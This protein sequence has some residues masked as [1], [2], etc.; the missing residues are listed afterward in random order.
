MRIL[1]TTGSVATGAFHGAM[2]LARRSAAVSAA[3]FALCMPQASQAQS[4][5]GAN[6]SLPNGFVSVT[7]EDM[8]LQTPAGPVKWLRTWDGVEWKFNPHWESLSHSWGNLTGSTTA[9]SGANVS[10]GSAG[11]GSA[12]DPKLASG[13]PGSAGCWVWVDEDWQPSTGTV[14]VGQIPHREPM[15]TARTAP[16]NRTIGDNVLASQD[17]YAP[18]VRVNV[19]YAALCMGTGIAGGAQDMEAVRR[20]NELYVGDGG[21]MAFNNRSTLEKRAVKALPATPSTAGTTPLQGGQVQLAPVVIEK[22][23]RWVDRSGDWIDY[24]TPGQVV[25]YGDRNGNAVWLQRDTEGILRGV[26]DAT[27]HVLLTLHYQGGLISEVRDY[28]RADNALDLPARSVKYQYDEFNRLVKV[29]GVQGHDTQYA[30]DPNHKLT[31]ITDAEGRQENFAYAGTSISRHTAPDGAVTDY[32]FEFDDTHKQF[33]SKVKGPET[34]TGRLVE[35]VTHNRAGQLVRRIVNGRID[36]ELRYD[37]GARAEVSTNARGFSTR[38]T[39]N[40]FEQVV[41][42]VHADRSSIKR[43]YSAVH[44]ELTEE[45]DEE[46]V[47][48]LYEHDSKG[49]LLKKT[50]AAG[51]PAQRV[52]EYGLNELGQVIR[53]TVK[54]R[55]EAD[56][57]VTADAVSLIEYD[58]L[59]QVA[60][61]TDPEGH[62]RRYTYNRAGHLVRYVDPRGKATRYEVDARGK[63][64]RTTD[65]L[66]RVRSFAYDKVGNRISETDARGKAVQTSYD[67]M[68]RAVQTTN[69]VGGTAK[70]Q[71]NG[72]GLPVLETDEDGRTTRTA[73]DNFLRMTRQI[74]SAGNETRFG[75]Q[76]AD[77][78]AAGQL[79]SLSDPTEVAYPTYT[80]QLRLDEHERP[81]SQTLLY[82]NS[83]E[84]QT[85]NSAVAYDRRGLVTKETDPSGHAYEHSYDALRQRTETRDT[86]GGKTQFYYD[87][88]GNLIRLVDAKGNAYRFEYDRNNREVK[89]TLPG[90]QVMR[91]AYDG[92]GNLVEKVLASGVRHVHEYDAANR[93]VETR[94]YATD[95]AL[96]RTT[97]QT[98]DGND[99]LTAWTDT[100]TSRPGA[101]RTASAT[102]TYDDANRKTA[103]AVAY[104]TPDGAAYSLGYQQAYSPAGKKTRLTWPD[105]TVIEYGWSS[106][107]ELE[108]VSIPGEGIVSVNQFKWTVPEKIT[109]PGGVTQNKVHDGLLNVEGLKVKTPAQQSVLELEHR[110]GK[111]QELDSRVRTDAMAGKSSTR[112]QAYG[113]DTELRLVRSTTQAGMLGEES[114]S[115]TLDAAGN[116]VAQGSQPG[117]WTYDANNRLLKRG[118]GACTDVGT[119]CYDWDDAGNLVKKTSALGTTLFAYDALNRLVEVKTGSG[120]IV[121]RYGYD[122]QDRRLWKEQFRD[123]AGRALAQAKR[124]Y[125]LYAD[126]GLI[127]EAVQAISLQAD[128][129]VA[130]AGSPSITTQYGPKPDSDFTTGVL[131]V[132]TL[133]S[134]GQP[135]V[136]YYHHDHLQTPIQATDKAGN[137]V[138]AAH[139]DAFG[140]ASVITPA[141]APG[142]PTI[143]SNL[144]LPG[145]YQDE[146]TGL[147]YNFRRYYDPQT[148][149]YITEDPIGLEGG[150][151][152]FLYANG[153]P[154]MLTDPT[155]EWVTVVIR[156]IPVIARFVCRASPRV[157]RELYRCLTNPATCK[158]RFC[159]VMRS[160][161]LYHPVCDLPGCDGMKTPIGRDV[162]LNAARACLAL[163]SM[164]KQVCYGGKAD[165]DHEKEIR[166]A[167][168]KIRRCKQYCRL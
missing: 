156:L 2:A 106:H 36:E 25:A 166:V 21:R 37:T 125:Y 71:Y 165:A 28:P 135:V 49:N 77:G 139:Y 26:V 86:I 120:E 150:P 116:R 138:W 72:Q 63:L 43:S 124:T 56:G 38:T 27:G 12:S 11:S 126:E 61:E 132:K 94:Q 75:Y 151:N 68:N 127:A 144:R 155:G 114:E 111:L 97:T 76:V 80:Q 19:D 22:G 134:D 107:G 40:E 92:A 87:V 157:C 90:G 39:K 54:G 58:T 34:E 42:I 78:S 149:R 65:G 84:S 143:E 31:R 167:R 103:E 15:L 35:D 104:P 24:N 48:T 4:D 159:R 23:Y 9:D 142:R 98:W 146:E 153:N 1:D 152:L 95:G 113:Y 57:T 122:P 55:T 60:K 32:V 18:L 89:R 30:Y 83:R 17:T 137:V 64:L 158:K 70:T 20:I 66:G 110:F 82:A 160:K 13:S 100:D 119:T 85:V 46:G 67:A 115:Y 105:G 91:S 147:H 81:T 112:S 101:P 136:A 154:M 8:E 10:S 99:N 44:L 53:V 96:L 93:L 45:T 69:A 47:K 29:T 161:T 109:L 73:Y 62:V 148:G 128:G 50:E 123:Q 163:R 52:T 5:N 102:A 164:V 79:G 141:A 145:Q 6:I 129:S 162:A 117:A 118:D 59:G 108:S 133:G 140:A 33:I 3:A 168:E 74:D 130:V 121:A 41:E 131:F 51:T 88:R 16:F 7:V 14:L